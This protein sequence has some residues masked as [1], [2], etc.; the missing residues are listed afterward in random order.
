MMVADRGWGM[1]QGWKI[2]VAVIAGLVIVSTPLVWLLDGPDAGQIVGAS[3]QGATGAGALLWALLGQQPT[4]A[5]NEEVINTGSAEATRGGD[6]QTGI[7]GPAGP[8]GGSARAEH[9]G[10]AVADGP[11]SSAGTG[12]DHRP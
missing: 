4:P 2:T 6:A 8:G 11:D 12:I 9:T 5:G 7:R 3:V 10:R 1:S